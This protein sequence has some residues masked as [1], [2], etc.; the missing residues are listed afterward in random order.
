MRKVRGRVKVEKARDRG[1]KRR[2]RRGKKKRSMEEEDKREEINRKS[3]GMG[4][5]VEKG[6]WKEVIKDWEE[7]T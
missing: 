7:Y 4:G 5:K 1:R 2:I 3:E 6:E